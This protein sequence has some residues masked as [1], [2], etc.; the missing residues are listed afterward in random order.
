MSGITARTLD[1]L[2]LLMAASAWALLS[3]VMT[4]LCDKFEK[5]GLAWFWTASFFGSTLIAAYCLAKLL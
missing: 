4:A 3:A 1:Y 2:E 5:R